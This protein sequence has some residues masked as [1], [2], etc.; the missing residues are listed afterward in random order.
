MMFKF[1]RSV[2]GVVCVYV[3]W[4]SGGTSADSPQSCKLLFKNGSEI[5]LMMVAAS[6]QDAPRFKDCK[7]KNSSDNSLYYY[8]PC[9]SYVYPPDGQGIQTNVSLKCTDSLNHTLEVN[10]QT[11]GQDRR[12]VYTMTLSSRCACVDGCGTPILPHGMSLG[13]FL[14]L[15]LLIFIVTYLL[16]GYIYRRFV[17][18]AQGI[19]L[20]PHL[21]FW[22]AFPL[23][24]QDGFLFLVK[25]GQNDDTYER[26]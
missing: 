12:I 7:S 23:L 16:I 22:M 9:Y 20:L 14:L 10:G 17:I 15:L 13:S 26:I 19:E 6:P 11:Q 3:V 18:G 21:S 8:N 4:L 25:C 1:C 24:V 5:N 2:L